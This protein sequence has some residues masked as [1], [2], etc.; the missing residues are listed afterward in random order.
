MLMKYYSTQEKQANLHGKIMVAPFF[1]SIQRKITRTK[2]MSKKDHSNIYWNYPPPRM[3]VAT[4][5]IIPF[6]G[7]GIP[8]GRVLRIYTLKN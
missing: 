1:E 5:F 3:P 7:S 6:L 4:V 8:I 2:C